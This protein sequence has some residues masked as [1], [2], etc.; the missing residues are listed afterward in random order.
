M[1][2][3]LDIPP[4]GRT[5]PDPRPAASCSRSALE[6]I[7]ARGQAKSW[8][9]AE[10]PF[11]GPYRQS[12]AGNA[13]ATLKRGFAAAP[14]NGANGGSCRRHQTV[15]SQK[16]GRTGGS[17]AVSVVLADSDV[18]RLKNYERHLRRAGFSVSTADGGVKC[19]CRLR[20][21][22]PD[23]LVLDPRLLWGGADGILAPM[24]TIP[25]PPSCRHLYRGAATTVVKRRVPPFPC[26][27]GNC[28][29]CHP[30]S[31][32]CG[33]ARSRAHPRGREHQPRRF[34]T[35]WMAKRRGAGRADEISMMRDDSRRRF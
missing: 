13:G 23:I 12:L 30:G 28:G 5:Q 8:V 32:R 17:Q 10:A 25:R 35:E 1:F 22:A 29:I 21:S 33:F 15:R 19:I 4:P 34:L 20:E 16:Q 9:D 31:W 24:E 18:S 27:S 11:N 26:S 14:Q 3:F 6:S 7:L 2:E